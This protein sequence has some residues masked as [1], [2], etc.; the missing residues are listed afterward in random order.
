VPDFRIVETA[1]QFKKA[2]EELGY[3][4]KSVCFK[5]FLLFLLSN[6]NWD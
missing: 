2:V 6:R 5:P 3:P 1:E 4:D